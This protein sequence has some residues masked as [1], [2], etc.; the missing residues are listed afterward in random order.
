MSPAR[1]KA[2]RR[3]PKRAAARRTTKAKPRRELRVVRAAKKASRPAAPPPP[4]ATQT[5][6]SSAR[7]RVLFDLVMARATVYG[8]V[9]GLSA[10]RADEPLAP[11]K[12]SARETLLHL[13]A[14]DRAR[15]REMEEALRGRRVSWAGV[16]D[17][18]MAA[19]NARELEPLRHL[20]WDQAMAALQ[21]TRQELEEAL[22]SVPD[23]PAEVWGPGHP[24]GEMLSWLP[25][26]DRHH[27]EAIKKWR[28]E[29]GA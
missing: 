8:A 9:K 20:K 29:R 12:W 6:A 14:R 4:F 15:L 11:G 18:E 2:A 19:I 3:A 27:A 25:E 17:P 16:P 13:V 10:S 22:E 5:S 7:Q 24:F 26:H 28:A 21:A 23:E 1:R